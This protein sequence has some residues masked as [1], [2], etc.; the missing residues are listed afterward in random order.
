[1]LTWQ[2]P[3]QLNHLSSPEDPSQAP[4]HTAPPS[5][6]EQLGIPQGAQFVREAFEVILLFAYPCPRHWDSQSLGQSSSL[7]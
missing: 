1:M 7:P 4:S 3:Y 5:L 2:A 6:D